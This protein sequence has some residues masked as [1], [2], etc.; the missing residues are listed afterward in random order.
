MNIQQNPA[1]ETLA[2]KKA[3]EIDEYLKKVM[4]GKVIEV[5][6]PSRR[7]RIVC[8]IDFEQLKEKQERIRTEYEAGREWIR[9]MREEFSEEEIHNLFFCEEPGYHV[10][11]NKI[12]LMLIEHPEEKRCSILKKKIET[13]QREDPHFEERVEYRA[14]IDVSKAIK[15]DGLS[16][17][18]AV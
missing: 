14:L 6:P 13:L 9:T 11:R 16:P 12:S 10:A 7:A 15:C 4:A 3:R 5:G 17:T 8:S 2:E 18:V 1:E